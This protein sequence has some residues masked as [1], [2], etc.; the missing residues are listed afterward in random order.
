M[1]KRTSAAPVDAAG[2]TFAVVHHG[3][4]L[5]DGIHEH[6]LL[7]LH[8]GA[9]VHGAAHFSLELTDRPAL[10]LHELLELLFF[11]LQ[12]LQLLPIP[13]LQS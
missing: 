13:S 4:Q 3:E 12:S 8:D 7:P 6:R 9:V 11:A 1:L 5:L 10:P 2:L